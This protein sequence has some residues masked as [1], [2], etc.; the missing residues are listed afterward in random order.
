MTEQQ[1]TLRDRGICVIIPTYNNAGTIADV[2]QRA[3]VQCSDVIV[4]CD[5]CTDN[6]LSLLQNLDTPLIIVELPQNSGKGS[7]LKAG[8]REALNRGFAYAI[9][10]DGDGQ[11][12]PEDIATLLQANQKHPGAL[13]VGERKDLDSADRSAGSKFANSFSN[14]WFAVQTWNYLKDTQTGYRLYPLKKLHGLSLLTSRYE[15]ELELMVFA[16]WHGVELV[17]VPVNVYY[18]SREERVSHFR[19]IADFVRIFLLNT[20]LCGLAAIYGLPLKVLR[21]VVALLRTAYALFIFLFFTICVMTPLTHIY[22]LIG[23]ITERK[24]YNLHR[25]LN[26]AARFILLYH[27]IPGVKYTQGN[28]YNETFDKPSVIICNHQSH[29]DLMPMLAQT[30][31]LIVLTADWVWNNPVYRYTIRNAEYLPASRGVEAI[32]PQLK[33]LV[34][35]GYHIAVYPEGTRSKN[36]DIGRFHKGAFH[37]AEEL[38]LDIIPMVLYGSGKALPKH[39]RILRRWPMHLEICKRISSKEFKSFGDTLMARTSYMRQYY[40]QEYAKLANRIEQNV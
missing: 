5:G 19:P 25:L 24:R 30:P 27:K 13:I 38:N 12:F 17:S 4:V 16:S 11:H 37:I 3:I 35:R 31:K 18:P 9:T 34:E 2:V 7:A 22:L 15:A 39:G 14:F 23:K 40:K 1:Q 36:C 32:M 28:P 6:T 21:A 29:L 26:F 8:F 20:I 10:L 33:S